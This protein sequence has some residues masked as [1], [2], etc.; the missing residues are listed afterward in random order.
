MLS[1]ALEYVES[2]VEEGLNPCFNGICSRS[3][4]PF[5]KDY[6]PS[7]L[8]LVLMEYALEDCIFNGDGDVFTTS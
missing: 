5:D 7:V 6:T 2:E 3:D 8:I 1:K 4:K